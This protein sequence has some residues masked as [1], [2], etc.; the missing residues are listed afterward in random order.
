MARGVQETIPRARQRA[1]TNARVIASG[2]IRL[3]TS[4][5]MCSGCAT[6]GAQNLL[7]ARVCMVCTSEVSQVKQG[8]PAELKPG[9]LMTFTRW[10]DG[11]SVCTAPAV[12]VFLL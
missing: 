5:R 1:D 9:D 11:R 4:Q 8:N 7:K 3:R 12:S 2:Q 10:S 6:V